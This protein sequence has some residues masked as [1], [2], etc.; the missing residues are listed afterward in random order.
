MKKYIY[1]LSLVALSS[2]LFVGCG[3]SNDDDTMNSGS[4]Y[5]LI[6]IEDSDT[7]SYSEKGQIR[8]SS[9]DSPDYFNS[10]SIEN[11]AENCGSTF[12]T[13]KEM[14]RLSFSETKRYLNVGSYYD[15]STLEIEGKPVVD[16]NNLTLSTVFVSNANASFLTVSKFFNENK[17]LS[18]QSFQTADQISLNFLLVLNGFSTPY[19]IN[20][21]EGEVMGE[22]RYPNP[23][24][25]MEQLI[26][27]YNAA[28]SSNK[29][30]PDFKNPGYHNSINM[31]IGQ[32]MNYA[33]S[34]DSN[35]DG[36]K[37]GLGLWSSYRSLFTCMA[38]ENK[39]LN[40]YSD[41]Y[42]DLTVGN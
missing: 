11:F 17:P 42:L 41:G 37:D 1:T 7:A 35:S 13:F 8:M 2:L 40:V 33:Q 20:E 23:N 5:Q 16:S 24:F 14:G 30:L 9:I 12:D 22:Y 36:L 18:I 6:S 15:I 21:G 29:S 10:K 19:F 3:S 27:D 39:N 4:G 26:L 34:F 38:F 31:T 32:A 28:L 25:D